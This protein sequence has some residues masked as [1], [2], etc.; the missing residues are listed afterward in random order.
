[1]TWDTRRSLEVART[2][3]DRA[4]KGA[5]DEDAPLESAVPTRTRGGCA[6]VADCL[7]AVGPYSEAGIRGPS[8]YDSTERYT[9][10]ISRLVERSPALSR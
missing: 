9:R 8:S 2:D 5:A 10:I 3:V 6:R 7:L 4:K 1:M